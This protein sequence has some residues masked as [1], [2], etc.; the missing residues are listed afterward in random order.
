[1]IILKGD[2]VKLKSGETGIVIDTWGIARDW[3][4]VDTGDG[5]IVFC[6]TDYVE[7]IIKR[8]QSKRRK[9]R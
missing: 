9:W 3:I 5:Q 2:E 7:S 4:K 8:E 6:M 1:M